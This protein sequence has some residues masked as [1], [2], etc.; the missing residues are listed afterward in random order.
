M[1][2]LAIDTS[3]EQVSI[4]LLAKGVIS[5]EE[6]GSQKTQAQILL[7]MIDNLMVN[8]GMPLAELDGIIFGCGP[9]SFT[10]LRIVCSVAK[11][12]AYANNLD[13]IPVSSL[14]AIAWSARKELN[15]PNAEVLALVDARMQEVYWRFFTAEEGESLEYVSKAEKIEL[16]PKS[17]IVLAGVGIDVYW[18]SL[19]DAIKKDIRCIL[20]LPPSASAMI[21]LVCAMGIKPI[22][23]AQAQPVYVRNQVTQG[24]PRG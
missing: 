21:E 3:T 20:H 10:G 17:S 24:D 11:G 12:L 2:L 6:Q 4:A 14:A 15:D 19:S 7:P 9:G 5:S 1:N 18:D 22:P 13:L 16:R 8:A 23:V